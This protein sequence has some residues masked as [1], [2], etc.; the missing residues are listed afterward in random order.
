MAS[1]LA[2]GA[3]GKTKEGREGEEGGLTE[4]WWMGNIGLYV[5]V[6]SSALES[7]LLVAHYFFFFMNNNSTHIDGSVSGNTSNSSA[8]N[9]K[10]HTF[11]ETFW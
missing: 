4:G 7:H 9:E 5:S 10:Q 1:N 3:E 11:L 8:R 2:P 6:C